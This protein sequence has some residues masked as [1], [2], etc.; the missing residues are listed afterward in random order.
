MKKNGGVRTV[1]D[2]Q[3]LEGTVEYITF[4]NEQ[5]GFTVLEL[6]T[7]SELI[8]VVGTFPMISVGETLELVGSFDTHPTFGRQFKA[9]MCERKMPSTDAAILRGRN[10]RR[11]TGYCQENSR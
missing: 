4:H 11:R 5:N 9:Q 6:S 2:E 3:K 10:R 1:A 8:T 7:D